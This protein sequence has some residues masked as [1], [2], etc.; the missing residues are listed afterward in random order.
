MVSLVSELA[1]AES[2]GS[3]SRS[4]IIS[5]PLGLPLGCQSI[6]L[7]QQ[8]LESRSDDSG[9]EHRIKVYFIPEIFLYC[10]ETRVL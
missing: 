10:V 4:S 3:S 7:T 6:T 2:S 5:A 8:K 9:C 1:S